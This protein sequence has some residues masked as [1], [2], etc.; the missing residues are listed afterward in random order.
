MRRRLAGTR[1]V[2]NQLTEGQSGAH[3]RHELSRVHA[4]C[5]HSP[6]FQYTLEDYAIERWRTRIISTGATRWRTLLAGVYSVPSS[7]VRC[8]L[9]ATRRLSALPPL[10]LERGVLPTLADVAGGSPDGQGVVPAAG[11]SF[12]ARPGQRRRAGPVLR[13]AELPRG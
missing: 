7:A 4:E 13:A 5:Q 9:K 2:A 8:H 12:P 1:V 6:P 3:A 11:P 10:L